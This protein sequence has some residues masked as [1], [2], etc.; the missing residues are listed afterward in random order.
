ML[1]ALREATC[2]ALGLDHLEAE[3]EDAQVPGEL[4]KC[5]H[6][7]SRD[8]TCLSLEGVLSS[9]CSGSSPVPAD[10]TMPKLATGGTQILCGCKV[11]VSTYS[12]DA[13]RLLACN[14]LAGYFCEYPIVYLPRQCE[15]PIVYLP[16]NP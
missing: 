13:V 16:D 7:F 1:H 4:S 9:C 14:Q 11:A 12:R 2:C 8:S 3:N 10:R 5:K 6:R 15:Y